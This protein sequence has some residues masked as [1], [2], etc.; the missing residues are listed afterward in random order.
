[1]MHLG[2]SFFA[3]SSIILLI[4]A[5]LGPLITY[6]QLTGSYNSAIDSHKNTE[7]SLQQQIN[8]YT[9]Q[10]FLLKQEISQLTNLT[11]P[12]LF[13]RIGWYVHKSDDPVVESKN[14][15][16]IYGSIYNVGTLPA[17]DTKLTVRFFG[18]NQTLLQT[19][20]IQLGVV[21]SITNSTVPFE[22]PFDLG[23]HNISCS[24]ADAVTDV[25][26]SINYK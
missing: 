18:T 21:P 12:Y 23:K 4:L 1:M 15:F 5:V 2:K 7:N 17:N 20:E 8:N 9:K 6:S 24:V 10:N 13:T 3:G 16:T 19:S 14:T 25:E 11:K 26:V 22:M